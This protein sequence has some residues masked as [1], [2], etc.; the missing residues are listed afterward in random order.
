MNNRCCYYFCYLILFYIGIYCIF[1]IFIVNYLFFFLANHPNLINN[2]LID[3]YFYFF[4]CYAIKNLRFHH[5]IC[6][7][8]CFS[9]NFCCM[10]D[11]HHHIHYNI[12]SLSFYLWSITFKRLNHNVYRLYA[13]LL[14][15]Q[16]Y[17]KT[18]FIWISYSIIG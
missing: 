2:N 13:Y 6:H 5:N 4:N 7:N 1:Q 12:I 14:Y 11:C 16:I 10:I 3:C 15:S 9:M 8:N 17:F 18:F